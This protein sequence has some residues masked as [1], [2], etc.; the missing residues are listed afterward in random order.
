MI[1]EYID[2]II[3]N[4]DG[5]GSDRKTNKGIYYNASF[6]KNSGETEDDW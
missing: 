4:S 1:K 6:K 5:F 2:N 3:K